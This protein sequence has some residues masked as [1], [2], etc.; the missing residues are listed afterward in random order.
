MKVSIVKCLLNCIQN[1]VRLARKFGFLIVSLTFLVGLSACGGRTTLNGEVFV[2]TRGGENVE[3][4]LVTVRAIPSNRMER[5]L[6]QRLSE[7]RRQARTLARRGGTLLDSLSAVNR[8]VPEVASLTHYLHGRTLD[9]RTVKLGRRVVT[10][11]DG[12]YVRARPSAL[13]AK[14]YEL[15]EGVVGE[16]REREDGYCRVSFSGHTDGW[17]LDGNLAPARYYDDWRQKRKR[18]D[19]AEETI[20]KVRSEVQTIFQ[21]LR[22]LRAPEAFLETLP[23]AADS[24]ETGSRGHFSLQLNSE[25]HYYLIARGARKVGS[26]TETYTW[27]V[28]HKTTAEEKEEVILSNDNMGTL[29]DEK[30][31]LTNMEREV[32]QMTQKLLLDLASEGEKNLSWTEV[33]MRTALPDQSDLDLPPSISKEL[34]EV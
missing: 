1:E 23:A 19:R 13:S 21:Q 26:T 10:Q 22:Q 31:V 25:T 20:R 16:I 2:V 11:E 7:V 12:A 14:L 3:L 9:E 5:H 28:E 27:V 6:K 30:Y 29:S 34:Q 15:E 17:T 8:R 18:R 33:L 24:S 4:G 32:L